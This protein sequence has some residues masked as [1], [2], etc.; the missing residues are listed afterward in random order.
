MRKWT[1]RIVNKFCVSK[2][3]KIRITKGLLD[4]KVKNSNW[5]TRK[6]KLKKFSDLLEIANSP[7]AQQ[8]L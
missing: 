5:N 3:S 1:Q 8:Q 4:T 7:G 2:K 6:D